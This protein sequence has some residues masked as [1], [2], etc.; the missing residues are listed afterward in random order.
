MFT[1]IDNYVAKCITLDETEK[2]YFHSLLHH[3]LVKK[4]TFLQ[5]AGEVCGFEAYIIKG[6]IKSYYIDENGFEVIL[7]FAV[8]NWW[9]GDIA[10]FSDHKKSTLNLEALEDTEVLLIKLND[11][12]ELYKKVPK[13]ERMFRIMIQRTHETMMNRLISTISQPAEERYLNFITKYPSIPQRVPQHQIA[14]FLG[15]SP[16]FLSK[17]KA[18]LARNK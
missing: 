15:I 10:N 4:K 6:C 1:E 2:K 17:I 12:E 13:F 16:E 5:V 7:H 14:S 3:Q 9:V 11:K 8:E 18:K